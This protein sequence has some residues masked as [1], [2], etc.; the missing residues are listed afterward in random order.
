MFSP[1]TFFFSFT[2]SCFFSSLACH[3]TPHESH[4]I[5][6]HGVASHCIALHR[7]K[8]QGSLLHDTLSLTHFIPKSCRARQGGQKCQGTVC[9]TSLRSITGE[10]CVE[11]SSAACSC[12]RTTANLQLSRARLN[13]LNS[14]N[15]LCSAS[16][17]GSPTRPLFAFAGSPQCT[18]YPWCWLSPRFSASLSPR[19]FRIWTGQELAVLQ[20][21]TGTVPVQYTTMLGPFRNH[22]KVPLP[23]RHS[24]LD[25]ID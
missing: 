20:Y 9:P 5:S 13:W 21:S 3:I 2:F 22:I 25:D 24:D 7:S 11:T 15:L 12:G 17:P 6:S 18:V 4:L 14:L 23:K 16:I 1:P 10:A 8:H 19:P